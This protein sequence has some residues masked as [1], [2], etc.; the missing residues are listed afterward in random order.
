MSEPIRV[1]VT[2]A[3]G[4]IAYSLLYM[5]AKGDVFG[6]NQP[7]ILHLLDIPPMMGVLEGVV[8]ELADCALPLLRG[9]VPTAD[10]AEAFK[11]VV[12]AFL[13]GA[14]PRK[15]GM[16][17]KD[18]LSA[19]VKIFKVQGEALDKHA[20]KNVKVLVVGNPANTNALICSR[21]AP[22]I[23]RENFTAMTRLDQNRAQAQIAARVNVPVANVNNIVIWGNHSSTQFP[24][25][26][27]GQVKMDSGKTVSVREAVGDDAWL[28]SIFVET[29]QK[30]GAAVINARKMSSAMS[31]AK[32]AGDHMKDWFHG[33]PAGQFVSMGVVSDGS[34]GTPKDVV[35][36]F[37]VVIKNKKWEIVKNLQID[38]F[39]R[40]MLDITG[41]ELE[42]ER[43]EAL[44]I[45]GA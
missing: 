8:M 10:P 30:R 26:S 35:F 41:K 15:Q 16:E 40:K 20:D 25:G 27:H 2:G 1:V 29:V 23:P 33:T 18:L 11:G 36:S 17:R 12:A 22:S 19:N 13:V 7:L 44:A 31:A 5:I 38:D 24:D 21:F 45:I 32:A 3:A 34:Y 39:G 4:Q 37:P 43:G 9:V 28:R 6:P 42:E 14:M